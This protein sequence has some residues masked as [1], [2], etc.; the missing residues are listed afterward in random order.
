MFSNVWY[1]HMYVYYY[2]WD[3]YVFP[4]FCDTFVPQRCWAFWGETC[5]DWGFPASALFFF[6]SAVCTCNSLPLY[7]YYI[8]VIYIY[9]YIYI[10]NIYICN[11]YNMYI[12]VYVYICIWTYIY[13]HIWLYIH[14]SVHIY[15][16]MSIGIYADR[17]KNSCFFFHKKT[18]S[19]RQGNWCSWSLGVSLGWEPLHL[20]DGRTSKPHFDARQ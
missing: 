16:T 4:G 2:T 1:V 10:C 5:S 9:I 18:E 8:Y 6:P 14:V 15:H 19:R 7:I 11:I 17:C 12:Y 3:M 20:W 13:T